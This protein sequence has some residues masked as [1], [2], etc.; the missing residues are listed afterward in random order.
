MAPQRFSEFSV[1]NLSFGSRRSSFGQNSEFRLPQ[2]VQERI[3]PDAWAK[4]PSTTNDQSVE[5]YAGK[6]GTEGVAEAEVARRVSLIR[7]SQ[8]QF[9]SRLLEPLEEDIKPTAPRQPMLRP[10]QLCLEF[11]RG[12]RPELDKGAGDLRKQHTP[13]NCDE[14]SQQ[15][16][17]NHV[18]SVLVFDEVLGAQPKL[19]TSITYDAISLAQKG[20]RQT[21]CE[22]G[23]HL[24]ELEVP[25]STKANVLPTPVK[26]VHPPGQ[27][28]ED[29][30]TTS[31]PESLR[32]PIPLLLSVKCYVDPSTTGRLVAG[33]G[34]AASC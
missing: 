17:F 14:T 16:V 4:N 11:S 10:W 27:S 22:R 34:V 29:L 13:S 19:R 6:L 26:P 21:M 24:N 33:S 32:R 30:R 31:A 7:T 8:P 5:D 20:H 9:G 28:P 25:I 12:V 15:S 23:T 3:T 2:R 18:L 1:L